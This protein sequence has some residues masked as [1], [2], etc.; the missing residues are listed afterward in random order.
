MN[1]DLPWEVCWVVINFLWSTV[2]IFCSIVLL[3]KGK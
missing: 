2:L 1:L 3:A